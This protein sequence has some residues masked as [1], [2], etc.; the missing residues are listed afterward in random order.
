MSPIA[1]FDQVVAYGA[2]RRVFANGEFDKSDEDRAAV[3]EEFFP[4]VSGKPDAVVDS[5]LTVSGKKPCLA[6][7]LNSKAEKLRGSGA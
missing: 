7:K 3:I 4:E 5:T 6:A 2:A 1:S